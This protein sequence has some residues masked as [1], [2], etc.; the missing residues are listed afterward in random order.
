M[1]SE[2]VIPYVIYRE[3]KRERESHDIWPRG[4]QAEAG[5]LWM[6]GV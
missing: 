3:S 5:G 1:A 6:K 2:V 4:C